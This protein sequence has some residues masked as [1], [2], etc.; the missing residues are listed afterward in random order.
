MIN[1]K[2]IRWHGFMK[3]LGSLWSLWVT[4]F[5]EHLE[6]SSSKFKYMGNVTLLDGD[7]VS[8]II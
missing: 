6:L 8:N 7:V 2:K 3:T 5:P 4:R 1:Y